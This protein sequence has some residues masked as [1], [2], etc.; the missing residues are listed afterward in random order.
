MPR[1][2]KRKRMQTDDDGAELGWE[3][4]FDYH[5][6]DEEG[7]ATSNLKILEMAAKWKKMQQQQAA[8]TAEDSDEDSDDD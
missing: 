8:S 2:V 4:Y 5:F 1:R 6:P 7:A 3:E